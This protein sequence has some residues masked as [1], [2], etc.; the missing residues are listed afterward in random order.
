VNVTAHREGKKILPNSPL[1]EFD[2]ELLASGVAVPT[3]ALFDEMVDAYATAVFFDTAALDVFLVFA[4]V[5]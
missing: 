1:L 3:A 4:A 5:L 2:V